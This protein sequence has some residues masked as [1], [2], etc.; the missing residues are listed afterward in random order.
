MPLPTRE[1]L[2]HEHRPE[3]V[4]ERLKTRSSSQTVSD[5]VL[6][7][8]DGCI[9]TFAIVTASV[10]AGFPAHVTLI[11]GFAKL[12]AD[13]LSMAVSNYES[14]K[15]HKEFIDE[16]RR[17]EEHH[18]EHIPEGEREEIRQIFAGK[19]FEGEA[20]EHVVDTI[21]SDRR[22]WVDTMLMEEHGLQHAHPN[23]MRSAA[24]TFIAF[25]LIGVIPLLPLLITPLGMTLQLYSSIA[26]AG[27]VFFGI[28]SLKSLVL[29]LP[30]LKAGLSTLLTGGAAAG[31][32]FLVGH[33]LRNAFGVA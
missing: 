25:V 18:V 23:P 13:A 31:L 10:G 15:A 12:L 19:G 33:L 3:A 7:G 17:R 16:T 22:L 24:V 14:I 32:A 26:L 1:D 30:A 11:M 5:A 2:I 20:L 6:G 8:T 27:I 29:G 9:T 4:A 21:T 28:G